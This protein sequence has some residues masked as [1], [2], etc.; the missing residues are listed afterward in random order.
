MARTFALLVAI[1]LLFCLLSTA[2]G[3]YVSLEDYE[4]EVASEQFGLMS[5]FLVEMPEHQH[6]PKEERDLIASKLANGFAKCVTKVLRV[7][8]KDKGLSITD[9]LSYVRNRPFRNDEALQLV[10][11]IRKP[12]YVNLSRKCNNAVM[13]EVGVRIPY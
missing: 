5:E 8:T 4:R 13:D 11:D 7:F 2:A 1:G 3:E 10:V 12:K 9:F 6:L